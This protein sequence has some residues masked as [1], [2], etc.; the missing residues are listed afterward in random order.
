MN[1]LIIQLRGEI[2]SSNFDEWKNDLIAQIQSVNTE[3]INDHDFV[4]ATRYV[5]VFKAAERSLREAKQSAINQAA[6]IQ[7]LFNAI[8]EI[9][10]E[11]R[12]VRLSLERQ[13]K[14]RKLE[15]KEACIQSGIEV[16]RAFLEQQSPDFQLVD[17]STYVDRTRFESAVKRK[18]GIQ[19]MQAAIDNLCRR[20]TLEIS[21]KAVEIT[22][23]GIVLDNLPRKYKFLFQDRNSLLVLSIQELR[24]TIDKRIAV[25]NEDNAKIEAEKALDALR[26]LEDAELNSEMSTSPERAGIVEKE[27][28]RLII[29]ILS[30]KETAIDIARSIRQAYVDN[31][32]ISS[33]RLTRHREEP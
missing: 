16:V 6:D 27:E 21:Q 28:Y 30:S 15:I 9:A 1:Q 10:E 22:H 12:Q 7:R 5:K 4:V 14:T 26:K 13:I 29:D 18:A 11:T 23:N 32:S 24:L 19:R 3:L 8:D 20:I 17:H 25:F 31:T 2:Q 33:I